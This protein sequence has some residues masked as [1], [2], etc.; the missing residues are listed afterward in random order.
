M[1]DSTPP[2]EEKRAVLLCSSA[3]L[4]TLGVVLISVGFFAGVANLLFFGG[5]GLI[6]LIAGSIK[7]NTR[8]CSECRGRVEDGGEYC[9]HCA[10]RF[11]LGE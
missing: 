10:A 8:S 11:R 3:V 9:P 2:S 4:Q 5:T 6:L 1:K 7:E